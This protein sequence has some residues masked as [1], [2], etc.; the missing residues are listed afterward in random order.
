[1]QSDRNPEISLQAANQPEGCAQSIENQWIADKGRTTCRLTIVTQ[2]SQLLENQCIATRKKPFRSD[3]YQPNRPVFGS[4][5]KSASQLV[6]SQRLLKGWVR[7]HLPPSGV[8]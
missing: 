6:D 3:L 4:Q 5:R 7:T 8:F 1:M 2:K